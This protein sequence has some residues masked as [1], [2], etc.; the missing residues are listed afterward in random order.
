MTLAAKKSVDILPDSRARVSRG[1]VSVRGTNYVPIYCANCGAPGGG[2]PEKHMT[3]CFYLCTSCC[4]KHGSVAGTMAVPEEVFW[5]KVKQ[6]QLEEFGHLLSSE[7]VIRA[8][9][10]SNSTFAKLVREAPKEK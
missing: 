3:F 1:I 4:E 2:V 5:E 6:A 7:E 8:V 10:D 9:D